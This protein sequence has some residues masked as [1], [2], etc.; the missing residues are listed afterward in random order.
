MQDRLA[1]LALFL[2]IAESGSLSAAGRQLGL[3]QPSVSRQLRMLEDRLQ[4]ALFQR[5]THDL[6]LTPAGEALIADARAMVDGWDALSERAQTAE[7]AI[8][9]PVRM[10]VPMGLGQTVLAT[11]AAGMTA[12]HPGLSLDWVVDDASRDLIDEGIDLWVRAGAIND[13][14]LIVRPLGALERLIVAP[15]DFG[16]IEDV[17][18]L[19]RR[20]LVRLMP[21]MAGPLT[22]EG[23]SGARVS[24]EATNVTSTGALLAAA[25]MVEAGA[26]WSLLPRWLVAGALSAG[27]LSAPCPAWAPA[28]TP[29]ALAYPRAR[30]RPARVRL[31]IK[32]LTTEVPVL[33]G[34]V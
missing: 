32:A 23:P 28:P 16:A 21:F 19:C 5:S 26:G 34:S 9:G 15:A 6:T 27:R 10:L 22:L 12:R 17:S 1:L 31:L 20:P 3:S 13:D 11:W 29:I 24:V 7:A 8:T 18:D 4:T 14:T 25:A 30:F 2:R 33:L